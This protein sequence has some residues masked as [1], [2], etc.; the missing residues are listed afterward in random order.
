MGSFF[1]LSPSLST[2]YFSVTLNSLYS[3]ARLLHST[4]QLDSLLLPP[5]LLLSWRSA[6]L[7]GVVLR[8]T[9][10]HPF[11]CCCLCGSLSCFFAFTCSL[12]HWSLLFPTTTWLFSGPTVV[13]SNGS[14]RVCACIC[15]DCG[16]A[17]R[18]SV[19]DRRLTFV[20]HCQVDRS[21]MIFVTSVCIM[22]FSFQ[23]SNSPV[24][25]CCLV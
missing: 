22:F 11:Q 16:C 23:P 10:C 5:T 21:S 7:F 12:T 20:V 3:H 4:F 8:F 13:S 2:E 17:G 14:Q 24:L 19:W 15:L 18:I 25:D 1:S 6:D 9:L